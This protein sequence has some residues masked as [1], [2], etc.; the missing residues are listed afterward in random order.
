MQSQPYAEAQQPPDKGG[1]CP[2][3]FLQSSCKVRTGCK[4]E[5]KKTQS[6]DDILF[7][8]F[9]ILGNMLK[10]RHLWTLPAEIRP[11]S[12]D[13]DKKKHAS[14]YLTLALHISYEV[15]L[16]TAP[17]SCHNISSC[18]YHISGLLGY[19]WLFT[20]QYIPIVQL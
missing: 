1:P 7:S 5:V 10:D 14:V 13:V 20:T 4:V 19:F 6:S 12:D 3:K 18:L 2:N 16:Q 11:S 8:V 9:Q 17:C 15:S